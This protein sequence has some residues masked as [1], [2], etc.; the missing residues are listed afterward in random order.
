MLWTLAPGIHRVIKTWPP[1]RVDDLFRPSALA[2]PA[3]S[4]FMEYL[5]VSSRQSFCQTSSLLLVAC[6]RHCKCLLLGRILLSFFKASAQFMFKALFQLQR[7]RHR[8]AFVP[9]MKDSKRRNNQMYVLMCYYTSGNLLSHELPSCNSLLLPSQS[10]SVLL[11]PGFIM[12]LNF[13][14]TLSVAGLRVRQME[15]VK[16]LPH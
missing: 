2:F 9:S 16:N 7:N 14:L 1:I 8:I 15:S 5:K 6:P 13:M 3:L 4:A 10:A 11:N 12:R